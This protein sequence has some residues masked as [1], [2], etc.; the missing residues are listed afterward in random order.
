VSFSLRN[1]WVSVW[2]SVVIIVLFF[3]EFFDFLI[4]KVAGYRHLCAKAQGKV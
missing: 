1:C 4:I 2:L 3:S